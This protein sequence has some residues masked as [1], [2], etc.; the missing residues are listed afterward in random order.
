MA[1]VSVKVET[2]QTFALLPAGDFGPASNAVQSSVLGGV[3]H[4][5]AT[6]SAACGRI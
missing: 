5:C 3:N 4:P 6:A 1:Y 2:T